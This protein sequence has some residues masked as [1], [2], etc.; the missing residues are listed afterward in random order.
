MPGGPSETQVRDSVQSQL[1]A[2][3]GGRILTVKSLVPAGSAPLSGRDGR[4]KYFNAQLEFARDYD[5]T[6]WNAHSVSSLSALMGAGPKGVIGLREGGN[7][8]GDTL[9]VYGSAAFERHGD[10]WELVPV[11]QQQ[12]VATA[13]VPAAAL[14]AAVRPLPHEVPPP[15]PTQAAHAKLGELLTLP[16]SAGVSESE[17]DAILLE[18][19]ERTHR[20]ARR[21][22]QQKADEIAVAGGPTGGAYEETLAALEARAAAAGI[23]LTA[24]PTEGS[25]GN[26]RLLNDRSAQFAL[27][28]N[29]IAR[30]AYAGSGRFAGAPLRD[31]R[32]VASLFPETIQL[33]TKEKA[34]ISN[35]A[36]L[37]GKRVGLGPAG[38]GTRANA[39]AILT[40]S[41][42]AEDALA[43]TFTGTLTEA[44]QALAENRIDAFFIT[45]HA[46]VPELQRLAASTP[47]AWV[48]IGPS[49]ELVDSGLIPITIPAQTYTGQTTPIPTLAATALV[50]T[51][52]DVPPTQVERM[53]LLLFEGK[54]PV[55]SAAVSRIAIRT[56]REGVNLPWSPV[57]DAW[58]AAHGSPSP[59]EEPSGP[60]A[61]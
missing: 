54:H 25:V 26:I 15:S 60:R 8:A 47:L 44:A 42:L 4:L 7:R 33:V 19:F 31:L 23:A 52:D 46:P 49:R 56:A 16:R 14:T 20:D 17:R 10:R 21:R 53:L 32:A 24:L 9:G 30:S 57:A 11:A 58:L 39:R 3:L 43:E 61:P 51:R 28:Q 45:V 55:R 41:G 2:A 40:A 27:V 22:L 1:D 36:D 13:E 18:E 37:R 48:P 38:S 29:D 6:N 50:V 35:V 59:P 12:A 5:F 34:G